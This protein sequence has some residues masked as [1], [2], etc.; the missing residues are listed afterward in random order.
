MKAIKVNRGKVILSPDCTRV[1]LRPFH[2]M[3]DQRARWLR[4]CSLNLMRLWLKLLVSC[5]GV[6]GSLATPASSGHT[7][8]INCPDAVL[9]HFGQGFGQS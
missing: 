7:P 8:T 5:H 4:R 3:S 1:L 6:A 9:C 2:A